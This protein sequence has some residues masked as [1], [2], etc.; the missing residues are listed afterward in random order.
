MDEY[1]RVA[2]L[3][4]L[5]LM[6][7]EAGVLGAVSRLPVH[8]ARILRGATRGAAQAAY[9]TAGG[10]AKGALAYGATRAAPTVIGGGALLY[11]GAPYLKAKHREFQARQYATRPYYDPNTQRFI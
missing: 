11:A 10:G 5:Y 3:G 6:H 8:V 1:A 9:R 7:K 2:A 4:Q